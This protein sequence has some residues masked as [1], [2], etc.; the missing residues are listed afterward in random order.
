VGTIGKFNWADLTTTD[1]EAAKAFYG[2]LFGWTGEDQPAGES[3]VYT[4]FSKDG[5][6]VSGGGEA[7]PDQPM[8]P[9]WMCYVTV[10]DVDATASRV[11][12]SGG[13]TFMEPLD[14]MDSGRMAIFADPTGA[15]FG[16]WQDGTHT[17][18][19]LKNAPGSITWTELATA[20]V[21]TATKFYTDV[22]GWGTETAPMG[23]SGGEYTLFTHGED[24]IAGGYDKTNILPDEVPPHWLV[25]F[26]TDDIDAT[27]AKATELGAQN[28]G[29][30]I[31]VE[32]AGRLSVI[33]D[34]QGATFAALQGES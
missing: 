3:Q 30:I 10:E 14:V 16:V 13:K 8:P 33:T 4:M 17:G 34:P 22:F 19:E 6:L 15:V 21:A 18:A 11:A 26:A 28:V 5:K 20:D 27:A 31:D 7:P 9:A 32:M 12:G 1:R 23:D 29:D 24:Q 2:G 25:Y